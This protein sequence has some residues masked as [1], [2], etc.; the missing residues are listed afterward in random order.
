MNTL[1]L[2]ILL[3]ILF[4][5]NSFILA[6]RTTNAPCRSFNLPDPY[7]LPFQCEQTSSPVQNAPKLSVALQSQ[8][9]Y[10]KS[11]QESVSC[12]VH[13][14]S[15][16]KVSVSHYVGCNQNAPK[17]IVSTYTLSKGDYRMDMKT[18]CQ[19]DESHNTIA[20]NVDP[21]THSNSDGNLVIDC[22]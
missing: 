18:D 11:H 5:V 13:S 8:T 6:G 7:G 9:L 22:E 1:K 10:F 17:A 15:A 16:N 20:W 14:T 21:A 19:A 2:S 12:K 4:L 3:V